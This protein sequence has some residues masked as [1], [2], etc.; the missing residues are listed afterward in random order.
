[1]RLKEA[2][3]RKAV[4]GSSNFWPLDVR[5]ICGHKL[6]VA[7]HCPIHEKKNY[8]LAKKFLL[9]KLK[10][11]RAEKKFS[12]H[13]KNFFLSNFFLIPVKTFKWDHELTILDISRMSKKINTTPL[14]SLCTKYVMNFYIIRILKCC[15]IK[16]SSNM[17][18]I[19]VQRHVPT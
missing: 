8:D 15:S 19:N 2:G 14:N 6:E 3:P 18:S 17:H 10:I 7:H 13:K 12:R 16:P 4:H 1:M 9:S 11:W 5:T